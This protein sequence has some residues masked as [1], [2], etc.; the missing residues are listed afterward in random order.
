MRKKFLGGPT[1]YFST[2]MKLLFNLYIPAESHC[3]FHNKRV[4]EKDGK[5]SFHYKT[6]GK[7]YMMKIIE[8]DGKMIW[9][10]VNGETFILPIKL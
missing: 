2:N 10:L 9:F 5:N 8:L 7:H 1:T 3:E 6:Y 4:G